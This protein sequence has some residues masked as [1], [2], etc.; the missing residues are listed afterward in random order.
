MEGYR[1]QQFAYLV[2]PVTAG[3][4]FFLTAKAERR[5]EKKETARA[6][7]MDAFG[8][9]FIAL[10]P[11]LFLFTIFSIE[12][13][14]FPL[15]AQVL[16]RLDRYGVMF[17]FLGAWWQIF[18]ITALRARRVAYQGGKCFPKV[19]CPYL[20]FGAFISALVLWVAPWNLMWV[21]FF[22][23]VASWGVC[24]LIDVA[25]AKLAKIF[26]VL[27]VLVLIGENILFIVFDAIV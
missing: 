16:H 11:A 14:R 25:P 27:A 7:A 9:F 1:L 13:N 6:V 2:I 26:M 8:Y 22:W 24:G 10:I 18:L 21:S 15:M 23:F 12:Y 19:W 4:E 3:V 20:L 5:K 17:F